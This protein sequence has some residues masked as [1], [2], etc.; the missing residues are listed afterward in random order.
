MLAATYDGDPRKTDGESSDFSATPDYFVE[1]M[2][3]QNAL[4]FLAAAESAGGRITRSL[5]KS[6]LY[7]GPWIAQGQTSYL[8]GVSL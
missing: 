5:L 6:G 7:P 2:A 3:R 4:D 1:F 8:V